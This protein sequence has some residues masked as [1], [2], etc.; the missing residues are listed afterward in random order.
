HHRDNSP[1][2]DENTHGNAGQGEYTQV[3]TDK[4][5]IEKNQGKTH[6]DGCDNTIPGEE[7]CRH[8]NWQKEKVLVEIHNSMGQAEYSDSKC[9]DGNDKDQHAY[10]PGGVPRDPDKWVIRPLPRVI[11]RWLNRHGDPFNTYIV[12]L[13]YIKDN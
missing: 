13:H 12:I 3:L 8:G 9:G 7:I 6:G 5:G 1:N 2:P 10:D 11:F 4:E